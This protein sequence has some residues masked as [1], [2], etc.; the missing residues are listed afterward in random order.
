VAQN[1]VA[2]NIGSPAAIH[3]YTLRFTTATLDDFRSTA[4]V[5]L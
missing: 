1:D 4:P 3:G 5:D 2:E